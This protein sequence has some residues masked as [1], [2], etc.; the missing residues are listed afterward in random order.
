MNPTEKS[1][2]GLTA[3]FFAP[4][5][6]LGR[7]ALDPPGRP[8]VM[9]IVNLTSDSFY[10]D[11]RASGCGPA[12]EYSLGQVA[13]GADLIDLGAESTRPGAQPV[14]ETEEMD[15]LL[16]VLEA[17][18]K[19]TKVPVT[20][21]TVRADTARA[22]LDAGADAINDISA[23]MHDPEMIPLAAERC[24]GL[25]LMH[26]QGIPRTMQDAPKYFDVVAE[27]SGWLAARCRLALDEGVAPERL[28][29][30]PGIGFGKT[31]AHNLAL[32]GSLDVVAAGRPLLL[33][34]SRKRFIGEISGAGVDD[35][36]AGSLAALA[37]AWQGSASMVRVHDV[38]E[39]VQFFEVLKAAC[40]L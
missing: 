5:W 19:E 4:G 34:A 21:D 29:V 24:C 7:L 12:V 39:S 38:K 32:L 18:R 6:D 26:M 22:A 36:L 30:D 2:G 13:A 37:C 1:K 27:V 31:L 35:R 23:G 14:G 16:P 3:P 15:R 9:G 33:G 8:L 17:L 28:M 40:A 20:V 11:S 10:P 25:V